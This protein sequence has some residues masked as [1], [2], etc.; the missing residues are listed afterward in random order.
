MTT[1]DNAAH[2]ARLA[3]TYDRH[4]SHSDAFVTWMTAR[5]VD[6]LSLRRH[7]RIIDVGCGTGLYSRRIVDAVQPGN[8]LLCADPSSAMLSR[9]RSTPGIRPVLASAE[10][11]AGARPGPTPPDAP[12]GRFDAVLIK[13]AVHHVAPSDRGPTIAGLSNLLTE[14]GRL[15][16]VMLPTRIDY[17]LFAAALRRFEELQPDPA[18]I[19]EHIRRAGLSAS[20]EYHEFSL[21]IPRDRYLEMV[22][23]RYLSLLST[24]DEDAIEAGIREIEARHPELMLSFPDRFAFVLG[25]RRA[26][27]P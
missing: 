8:P 9:L 27:M 2:Y 4:W 5:I 13:E 19:V 12:P 18:E 10:Q 20:I 17:P 6:G 26:R 21:N 1:A 7:H 22:R 15:L 25:S 14:G 3:A 16:I 23:G 11:L 24:F